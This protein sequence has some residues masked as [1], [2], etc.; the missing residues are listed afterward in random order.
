VLFGYYIGTTRISY[1]WKN[2]KPEFQITSKVPPKNIENVDFALFWDVWNR[3]E[4]SYYDK[5]VLDGQRLLNGAISGMVGSLGDPYTVYLP[6]TQNSEFKQG[7][8]GEFEGIGAHLGLRGNQ[9]IVVEPLY[10]SPAQKAGIRIGDAILKVDGASTNGW[11]LT[12]AVE[13]IRGPKG[14]EVLLTVIHKDDTKAS[15]LKIQRDTIHV[16]SVEGWVKRVGDI[17]GIKSTTG[18]KGNEDENIAYIRLSQF[19]DTANKE[20]VA[21]TNELDL[22]IKNNPQVKGIIVDLR[23]NPGGYLN[24][25]Q[26]I[27]GEFLKEGQAV[28][29]QE[30][31]TGDR[32]TLSV[33]RN[34][35]FQQ[36]PVLVLINKGSASASEIVAGAL[37]DHNRARLVGETSFGKGTIQSAEDLGANGGLHITIAKW[38]TPNGTWIHDKGLK[39][40]LE[41]KPDEKDTSHD[42]QLE[43]AVEELLK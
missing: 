19:G 14:S 32:L 6:P 17:E 3:L 24:E 2:Y 43:K 34:G 38:L 20:W 31:G 30:K 9:I 27:A 42:L 13:K 22:K 39:P 8:A 12:Q 21:K 18:I 41:V 26:F 25:A 11:T 16:T 35:L 23:N 10:G 4:N 33:N 7:L 37:K 15:D 5:K 1:E 40:D 29:I 36:I 28:V